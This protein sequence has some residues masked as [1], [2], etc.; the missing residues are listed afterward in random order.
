[1][2]KIDWEIL[3][4]YVATLIWPI[5]IAII[6]LIFWKQ[7]STLVD[8]ITRKSERIQIPGLIEI[9]FLENTKNVAQIK[10]KIEKSGEKLSENLRQL[11]SST[12]ITQVEGIKKFGEDYPYSNFDQRQIL[13]NRIK[14][15]SI[16]LDIEDIEPL[17]DSKDTGHRIAAAISLEF[18]LYKKSIEPFENDKV[19]EFLSQSIED[20]NPFLRYE[21][22]QIILPNKNAKHQLK[23][24]L[25]LM[26]ATDKNNAIKYILKLYLENHHLT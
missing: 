7:L 11:I 24:K 26:K 3:H 8:R 12:V 1:M 4:Q 2:C 25:S 19:K 17:F 10:E 9:N 23:E 16:G 6:L 18:I 14:E 15:Y 13:E 21:A 22:L 5:F 20:S